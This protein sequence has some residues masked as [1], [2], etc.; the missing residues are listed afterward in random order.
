MSKE[1]LEYY[2]WSFLIALVVLGCFIL[3]LSILY[4][5]RQS[6]NRTEKQLMEQHFSQTLLQSQLEIQEQT[7]QHVSHELHDNLGQVASLIKINLN[8]ITLDNKEKALERLEDTRE[9]IRQLIADLKGLSVSLGGDRIS[10]QGLAKALETEV[11]RLNRTGEFEADFIQEGI[12]PKLDED[13]ATI[14]YRMVQECINNMVKHS[15]AR[16]M[17]VHLKTSGNLITLA[18]TDDGI[19]FEVEEQKQSNGAGL[20]NLLNRARLINAT[21]SIVST[22]GNGTNV[23]IQL[24]I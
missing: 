18:V 1:S 7:L 16:K 15:R 24:M 22:P 23:S 3:L 20:K 11:Q 2:L 4:S 10:Q 17:T 5:R 19:G 21:L 9:L 8:T 6:R 13:K 14:L 12:F